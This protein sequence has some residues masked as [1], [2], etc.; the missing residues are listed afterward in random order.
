MVTGTLPFAGEG[1]D[2]FAA[3]NARLTGDPVAPRSLNSELS[4]QVEEIILHAMERDP[5]KRYPT[6]SAMK[7]DLDHPGGVQ[8]TGRC[9]RLQKPAPW[10]R[11]VKNA[12]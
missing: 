9:H 11:Q 5:K 3:M 12:L 2:V 6:A 1:E 8:L 4:E 7:E 10:K